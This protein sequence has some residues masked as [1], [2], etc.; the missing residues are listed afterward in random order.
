MS[1]DLRYLAYT[2]M[3]TAGLWIPYIACQVM[4]NGFL[5]R[6]N[7]RDPAPRPV[8]LWGKRADRTY[9]NAVESFAPFAALVLVAHLTGKANTMT[10]FWATAFFWLRVTHAIVYLLAIPYIRTL[11]FTL[12]F[13]AV[14]GIF[15]EVVK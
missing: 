9:L 12:G 8:P 1:T 7:Y 3:L 4:T 13:V 11:V 14:A 6:E 10:A 2:A 15:W 5:G